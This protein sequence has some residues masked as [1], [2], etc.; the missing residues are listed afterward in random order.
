M[1]EGDL[2]FFFSEKPSLAQVL[3]PSKD[4]NRLLGK[5][6]VKKGRES[7]GRLWTFFD[8]NQS[9]YQKLVSRSEND[10]E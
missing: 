8:H 4:A 2:F 10:A 7:C 3:L 6:G 1:V 9:I 5:H